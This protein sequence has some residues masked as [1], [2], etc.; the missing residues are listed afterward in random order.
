MWRRAFC[1]DRYGAAE[2]ILNVLAQMYPVSDSDESNSVSNESDEMVE[3]N[4]D[5]E[6]EEELDVSG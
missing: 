3:C 4:D 5:D 1:E 6:N 2:E